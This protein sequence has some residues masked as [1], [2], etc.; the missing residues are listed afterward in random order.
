MDTITNIEIGPIIWTIFNFLLLLTLL[1][2][3]AWK[4]ILAA[5][6]NREKTISDALSRA[7]HAQ[8]EAERVLGENQKAMQRAEEDAQRVLRES[9]EYA[10]RM[11]AESVQKAQDESRRLLDQA[12]KEIERNKQQALNEMRSEVANLA[13]GATEKILK[14]TLDTDRHKRLVDDYLTQAAQVQN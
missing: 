1:R 2:V 5:L 12:Q 3:V 7:E 11:Q 8:A 10:E 6:S 14:E 4:P 13:V 9:R